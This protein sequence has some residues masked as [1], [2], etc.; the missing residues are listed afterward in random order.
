[1]GSIEILEGSYGSLP[2]F[3]REKLRS[4][5]KKAEDRTI[6]LDGVEYDADI[7][8]EQS[9]NELIRIMLVDQKIAEVQ[10]EIAFLQTTRN[11]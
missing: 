9:K 10:R 5:S 2:L 1:M 7:L 4:G 11:A 8:P 6:T 3:K